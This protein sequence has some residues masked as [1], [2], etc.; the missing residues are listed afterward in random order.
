MSEMPADLPEG[1]TKLLDGAHN[2]RAVRVIP[3]GV[4]GRVELQIL[5]QHGGPK[6]SR[7]HYQDVPVQT[8]DALKADPHPTSYLNLHIKPN[9]HFYRANVE[10]GKLYD[11]KATA[12][13]PAVQEH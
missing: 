8:V 3:C 10:D 4:H 6:G 12:A 2:I 5:F 11:P 7:Y 13:K 9:Y 1:F